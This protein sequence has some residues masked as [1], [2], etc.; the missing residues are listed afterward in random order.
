METNHP[1]RL[2]SKLYTKNRASAVPISR[3][4]GKQSSKKVEAKGEAADPVKD[5]RRWEVD[6]GEEKKEAG[7]KAGGGKARETRNR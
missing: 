7:R 5:K 4:N 2:L 3:T 1:Q 6:E